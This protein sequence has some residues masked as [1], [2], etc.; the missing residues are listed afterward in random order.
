VSGLF[1]LQQIAVGRG[2]MWKEQIFVV[3]QWN[4]VTI[5]FGVTYA[6]LGR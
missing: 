6:F 1:L 2:Y 3:C 4:I 5:K